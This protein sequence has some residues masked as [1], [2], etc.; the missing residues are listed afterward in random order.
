[1]R[2]IDWRKKVKK[3]KRRQKRTEL[4]VKTMDQVREFKKAYMRAGAKMVTMSS[5]VPARTLL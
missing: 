1:M 2:V 4:T 3:R 5:V